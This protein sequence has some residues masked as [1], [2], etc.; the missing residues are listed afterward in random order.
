VGDEKMDPH[1]HTLFNPRTIAIIGASDREDTVG[2]SAIRNLLYGRLHG[3]YR[4]EGYPGKVYAVNVRDQD[5][6]IPTYRSILDIPEDTIDLAVIAIPA[7]YV[8]G[9]IDECGQKGVK[10]VIVIS[11]GFSEIGDEGASLEDEVVERAHR[12]GIRILGPNCLGGMNV[13][14]RLNATFTDEM[15]QLGPLS[16]ISQSGA[17]CTTAIHYAKEKNIGFSHFISV[18][19]KADIDDADLVEYLNEDPNTKCIIIYVESLKDGRKFFDTALRVNKTTP[20]VVLK[21]GRT[22]AGAK[23]AAS[24][25]GSIAGSDTAY[26][27][28]FEQAGVYRVDTLE[29][30]YDCSRA[31]GYQPIPQGDRVAILTNSGGP[32]VMA[33]D[34]AE[35]IGLRLAEL[36]PKTLKKLN[37]YLPA[38]WSHSNP[39]DILGD[40]TAV[41]YTEVIEILMRAPEVDSIVVILTPLTFTHPYNVS[42]QIVQIAKKSTKPI[43]A[44]YLGIISAIS[45]RYLDDHG[46]P[47]IAWTERTIHAMHALTNRSNFLKFEAQAEIPPT[48]MD[49]LVKKDAINSIIEK[50]RAEGRTILD[51]I[52]SRSILEILEFPMT[53]GKLITSSRE[54]E[55]FDI[56]Y[57]VAMK[58]VSKQIVHKTEAKG[59]KINIPDRKAARSAYKAIMT[60]ARKYDPEAVIEGVW[61]EEMISGTE[62]IIGTTI[63]PTFGKMIMFGLGG[64]FVEILKD[65]VFRL[66]PIHMKN[67]EAMYDKIKS[68]AILEGAR[69][70]PKAD[71]HQIEEMLVNVSEFVNKF[72]IKEMDINPLMVTEKGLMGIDARIV[73]ED[74][75]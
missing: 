1:I 33:A 55:S 70:M 36:S 22:S 59:V 38:A 14:K 50:A 42:Q 17:L 39:I 15:V 71:R 68:K 10:G 9:V 57:P 35:K 48:P 74:P 30:M 52:E 72:P 29:A 58:V 41:R 19:D 64:I 45:G 63:D 37:D 54:I 34:Y 69:G 20:I 3:S 11:A 6:V 16:L 23:A 32:G 27:A 66:V 4:E 47:E 49:V 25:T 46:V 73:L 12:H 62:L 56:P 2:H 51:L 60:N 31:L 65:V 53:T 8:P 24:H 26:D 28:A 13:F 18:G 61:M 21:S 5:L 44:N 75:E 43:L 40:A 7:K 67:A